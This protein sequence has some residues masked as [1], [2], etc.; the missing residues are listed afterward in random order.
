M[1]QPVRVRIHGEVRLRLALTRLAPLPRNGGDAAWAEVPI[2]NPESLARGPSVG[3]LGCSVKPTREQSC[4][5]GA[6]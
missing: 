6:R 4:A 1:R 2:S 5:D 3:D